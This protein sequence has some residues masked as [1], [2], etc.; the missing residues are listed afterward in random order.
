MRLTPFLRPRWRSLLLLA[1]FVVAFVL[2]A[3]LMPYAPEHP[4]L[5]LG[6]FGGLLGLLKLLSQFERRR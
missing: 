1:V 6:L 3:V 2:F 4:W 5:A